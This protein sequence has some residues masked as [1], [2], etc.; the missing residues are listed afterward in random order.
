MAKRIAKLPMYLIFWDRCWLLNDILSA[1]DPIELFRISLIGI[2]I[3]LKI[4]NVFC[5]TVSPIRNPTRT[6]LRERRNSCRKAFSFSNVFFNILVK[7]WKIL[8]NLDDELFKLKIKN[9]FPAIS[10]YD[11]I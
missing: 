10:C 11:W 4:N 6:R 9:C 7:Q 2:R 3:I 8:I 1:K 5:I